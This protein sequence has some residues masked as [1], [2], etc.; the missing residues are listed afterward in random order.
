[1][2]NTASGISSQI[3]VG[4]E[5]T[6]GTRV[7]PTRFYELVPPETLKYKRVRKW[8]K[9]L[10]AN[11]FMPRRAHMLAQWVEGDI[12]MELSPQSAGIW[13][14]HTL[15]SVVTTGS[16]PYTH[17]FSH[18]PLDALGLTVQVNRP[19]SSAVDRPADYVGCQITKMKIE[20][21]VDEVVMWTISVYGQHED[22][23]QSL[24]AASYPTLTPYVFTHGVVTL[25]GTEYAVKDITL[26]ID[27]GL[28]TGRHFM[29]STN[30]E[31]PKASKS[32]KT[33]MVSAVINS[34]FDDLTMHNRFKN[35]TQ[36][37]MT[38]VFTSGTNVLTISGTVEYEEDSWNIQD[39]DMLNNGIPLVFLH[40]TSDTSAFQVVLVNSDSTP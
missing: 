39:E 37:A 29:R 14:K 21:K 27:T 12:P 19:D 17:T 33:R 8:S 11:R 25:S 4:V 40:S 13:F 15:G 18:G 1:M 9:A 34:D 2:A 3:G 36:G 32:A 20:A 6:V 35:Q 24:A 16:G 28:R 30:P 5:S 7:V 22:T 10:R 31:R 38:L 26:E 23:T